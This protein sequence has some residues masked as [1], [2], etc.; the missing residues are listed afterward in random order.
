[1]VLADFSLQNCNEVQKNK[2]RL[3]YISIE[4]KK[5][6]RNVRAPEYSEAYYVVVE[7]VRGSPTV[8]S[9]MLNM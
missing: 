9:Q 2:S 8:T 7:V 4:K 5:K 6:K 1:M 3:S